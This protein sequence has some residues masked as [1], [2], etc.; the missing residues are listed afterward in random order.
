MEEWNGGKMNSEYSGSKADDGLI[1]FY[2]P[3]RLYKNRSHSAKPIIPTFQYSNTPW[4][5]FEAKP[6]IC[7]P[8]Q[9][10]ARRAYSPGGG[11]GF[12]CPNKDYQ[13][14]EKFGEP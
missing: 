12:Q 8:V 2:D 7:D 1:L 4:H 5:L 10:P 9:L 14:G 3:C 6:I 13:M 11:P